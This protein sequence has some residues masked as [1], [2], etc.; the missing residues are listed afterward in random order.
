MQEENMK[1]YHRE[2]KEFPDKVRKMVMAGYDVSYSNH[3]KRASKTDRYGKIFLPSKI[4]FS[5]EQVIEVEMN[6]DDV[7]K[8]LIRLPYTK[9]LDA[10]FAMTNDNFV[11]TVWLNKNDDNHT[12]LDLSK[13][14]K[15]E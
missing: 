15:G 10:I 9:K 2:Q 1:I 6:G 3:A 7:V 11:K 5:G 13:Y 8:Y 4:Y 12:T 14:S